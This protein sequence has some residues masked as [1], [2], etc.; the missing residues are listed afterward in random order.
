[1]K[2]QITALSEEFYKNYTIPCFRLKTSWCGNE[3]QEITT[4]VYQEG[5]KQGQLRI[6]EYGYNNGTYS[7]INEE[8]LFFVAPYRNV[9]KEALMGA[10]YYDSHLYVPLSNQEDIVD[11]EYLLAKYNWLRAQQRAERAER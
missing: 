5:V 9:V 7:F 11:N 10:G 6:G 1:M 8:G 2:R 3:P 4:P